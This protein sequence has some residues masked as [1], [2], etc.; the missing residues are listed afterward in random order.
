MAGRILRGVTS[1]EG[2]ERQWER[3]G[4]EEEEMEK[5]GR[6]AFSCKGEQILRAIRAKEF[7][8]LATIE[9]CER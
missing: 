6:S 4:E 8:G 7:R 9:M 1:N 3:E 5:G 2:K